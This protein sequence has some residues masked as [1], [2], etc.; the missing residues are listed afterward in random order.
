MRTS[1]DARQ[2]V[3]GVAILPE[4]DEDQAEWTG[5]TTGDD[6][7]GKPTGMRIKYLMLRS[8]PRGDEDRYTAIVSISR[9]DVAIPPEGR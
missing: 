9:V 4:G 7:T 2:R 8:L 1:P 5:C 6:D 3:L